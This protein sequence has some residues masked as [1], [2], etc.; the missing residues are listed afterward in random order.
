VEASVEASD[1]PQSLGAVLLAA[2]SSSRL[3]R[4]KQL[5]SIDG[6]L[7]VR[8]QA[9]LL[10]NLRVASTIVV[11]GAVESE[12]HQA[13][14]GIPVQFVHNPNWEMGMGN[15]LA[16]GIRQLPEKVRGVLVLLCD[17]WQVDGDDLK[18]LIDVWSEQPLSAVA[19]QWNNIVGPPVIFPRSLFD[20]LSRLKGEQ[21]ARQV[22]RRG[23]TEI[24]KVQ[25]EHASHDLDVPA[26]LAQL[27]R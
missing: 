10:E 1:A 2:G 15:S 17:Q 20:R 16:C 21:G 14:D 12:V 26:D 19:A 8:R 5:V 11:T 7:L 9:Q 23:K 6:Q 27:D 3:G 4:P 25:M 18:S 13:L 22:L 24:K